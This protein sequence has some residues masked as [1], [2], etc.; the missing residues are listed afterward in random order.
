[1]GVRS[2]LTEGCDGDI[3]EVRSNGA[4]CS[5]AQSRGVHRAG[6]GV[7][8]DKIRSGYQRQKV[9]AAGCG[10]QV[11]F[12]AALAAIV[13][14]EVQ[15]LQTCWLCRIQRC[16]LTRST[17]TGWLDLDHIGAQAREHET[18]ELRSTV[19]QIQ[20][21]VRTQHQCT[22]LKKYFGWK[23]FIQERNN[24]RMRCRWRP[25]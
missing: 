25:E 20:N 3:H 5:E 24:S 8:E 11:Q 13:G 4:Q 9:G 14:M 23:G 17:A 22:A 6:F 16:V 2:V 12:D 10:R 21:A 1:M 7:F 15:A 18:C 19:G